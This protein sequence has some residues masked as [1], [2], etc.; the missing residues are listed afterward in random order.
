MRIAA[1]VP[2]I[3]LMTIAVHPGARGQNLL[4]AGA[5]SLVDQ[6]R[7]GS[8]LALCAHTGGRPVQRGKRKITPTAVWVGAGADFHKLNAGLGACDPAWSPDG[9]SLAV[10]AAEG[11]WIFPAESSV[12]SLRVEARLP[13]G[14]PSERTYRA[15]AHPKWSPDGALVALVVSN[16]GNSWVEVFEASS[17]RLFYTSPPDAYSFSWGNTARDLKVGDL[18][19]HLP[20][21]P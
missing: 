14:E 6:D 9:H 5:T 4:P 1:L 21:H 20:P 10:T 7:F 2:S 11:L 12:G 17:G 8:H 13:I 19:V 3:V 16:T 15:F 18:D